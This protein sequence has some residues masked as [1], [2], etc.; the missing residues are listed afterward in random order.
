[1]KLKYLVPLAIFAILCVFLAVG[2]TRDPRQVPS[3]FIGKPAPAFT[4]AKLHEPQASFGPEQMRGK[5]WLLKSGRR[6][7]FPAASSTR[8]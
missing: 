2:L 6:G 4:L 7:A 3:P 8:C 1:M 5:V